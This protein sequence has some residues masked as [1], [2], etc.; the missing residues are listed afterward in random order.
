MNEFSCKKELSSSHFNIALK[1]KVRKI[2]TL[3]SNASIMYRWTRYRSVDRIVILRQRFKKKNNITCI[4]LPMKHC[5]YGSIRLKLRTGLHINVLNNEWVLWKKRVRKMQQNVSLWIRMLNMFSLHFDSIRLKQKTV[6]SHY[7]QCIRASPT[8]N[9]H[10]YHQFYWS[11]WIC[12]I[13]SIFRYFLV[14]LHF[15][16]KYEMDYF[17]VDR[18]QSDTN[19][20][21]KSK[22][23]RPF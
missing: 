2:F 22:H 12:K 17:F 19:C 1:Y 10:R 5:P 21:C 7:F 3:R 18:E 4:T 16:F 14:N 15:L 11:Q 13:H 23:N 20:T 8:I 9:M 6:F